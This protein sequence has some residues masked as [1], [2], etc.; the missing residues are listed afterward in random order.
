MEKEKLHGREL[1]EKETEMVSG[2]MAG[3]PMDENSPT[4]CRGMKTAHRFA[5]I[6]VS[7]I[8]FHT[9]V[10]VTLVIK[11]RGRDVLLQI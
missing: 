3:T 6:V 8:N 7:M 9:H 2:G 5:E 1:T 10:T 4:Q 11:R